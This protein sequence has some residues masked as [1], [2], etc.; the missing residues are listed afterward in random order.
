[1]KTNSSKDHLKRKMAMRE[2]EKTVF[3]RDKAFNELM[4]CPEIDL[5]MLDVYMLL[6][7][8]KGLTFKNK[9]EQLKHVSDFFEEILATEMKLFYINSNDFMDIG[10]VRDIAKTFESI[11]PQT[12]ADSQLQYLRDQAKKRLQGG[13]YGNN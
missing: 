7:Q 13:F 6:N 10:E 2:D 8:A 1:L 4:P 12:F 11:N 3:F 5:G 9:E